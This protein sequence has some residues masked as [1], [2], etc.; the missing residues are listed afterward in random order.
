MSGSRDRLS[1]H[2]QRLLASR[3]DRLPDRAKLALAGGRPVLSAG[4]ALDPSAQ[5][6]IRLAALSGGASLVASSDPGR[7]R[8]RLR[9]Q[10]FVAQGRSTPVP[11]VREMSVSGA[12]G[13]L[14]AR[15][16]SP[17]EV[18]GPA[19]LLVY[20]HGGGWVLGDLDTHDELCRLICLHA[21]VHVVSV[22]YRLAPEHPFPAG[23]EDALAAWRELVGRA[24]ALGADAGRV[25]LG[26]DSAGANLTA[27][28][29]QALAAAGEPVPS[30]QLLL[31]PAVEFVETFASE[32]EFDNG[33]M[34]DAASRRWF[35]DCYIPAGLDRAD[36]RLSVLRGPL[37]GQPPALLV[38][39][40][41][42]P[43]RDQGEA[44]A[45]ALRLAGAAVCAVRF[46]GLL[47]GFANMTGIS[48]AARDAVLVVC[49][50]LRAELAREPVGAAAAAAP[51]AVAAPEAA[52]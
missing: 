52:G 21:G 36:P 4:Q 17:G 32:R 41:F 11:A 10:A 46:G 42:D 45:E 8:E 31:Y 37:Q 30:L 22:A 3:L 5:L 18:G 7:E 9:A 40:G 38:T 27:A 44:Y 16:Y 51:S 50:M 6:T 12:G 23:L 14:P 34:L 2:A 47:H 49:G 25:A 28:A 19:P 33:F 20:L 24:A 29:C 13:P 15:H 48:R 35:Q 43:L 1:L 39:A 26:G